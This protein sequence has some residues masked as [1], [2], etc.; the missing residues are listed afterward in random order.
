MRNIVKIAAVA[1]IVIGAVVGG[2]VVRPTAVSQAQ[3]SDS[4]VLLAAQALAEAQQAC[5]GLGRGEACYGHTGA[6][7]TLV[8]GGDAPLVASGDK[9]SVNDLERLSTTAADPAANEWGLA[10][11]KLPAGLPA[12]SDLAVI[13][14]LF[15]DVT[16]ARPALAGSDRPTLTVYNRGGSPANVR[17]GAGITYDVVG[18]LGAGE[19]AAADGRNEQGDWLRIQYSG[20]I[21]WVF[22]PLI[23]WDGDQNAADVL[24]VLL[25]NDVTPVVQ[26]G[27]PFQSFTLATGGSVC[28]AAPSGILLQYSGEQPASVQVN[29]VSLDFSKA[30][31]LLTSDSADGLEVKVLDGSAT[32]T[33]RGVPQQAES[34]EIVG[35]NLGGDDGLTPLD[36]PASQ[37]DYAFP[38]IAYAPL[39]LLPG[40]MACSVGLPSSD[41]RV[42]LRVGP[43]VGRGELGNMKPSAYAVLGWANDPDGSPWWQLDTGAEPSWVAQSEVRTLGLCDPVAQVEPPPLVMVAP[44]APAG[45]NPV[46]SV[47]YAPAANSVWQ[48][49]P[50][51]DNLIGECSGAPA[52]NFCD[53]L[54][55]I[56]PTASGISWRGMEPTPYSLVRTQTNVYVYSGPNGAGTGT[57]SM[58]LSFSSATSLNMTMS[59]ILNSEPNCQHVYYYTGTKNW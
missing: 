36:A 11:M 57:L 55:A 46:S 40:Q 38:E 2:G 44:V 42:V 50:G 1:I 9:V 34:G 37:G 8:G 12:E 16:V 39:A 52:I 35:I 19:Q 15:G 47:D 20:G 32:I 13:G 53:H 23:G 31:L 29:Q 33:A 25:P 58:T 41:A 27:E 3:D 43:G 54:A 6:A 4:C 24:E 26:A 18:Q 14:V 17:N 56:G 21:A 45:E 10:M 51:S 48:M 7:G 59:L 5:V 49:I 30:T 28:E 22:T